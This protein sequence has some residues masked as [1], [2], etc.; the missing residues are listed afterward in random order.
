MVSSCYRVWC[1]VNCNVLISVTLLS[2]SSELLWMLFCC[3]HFFVVADQC[4]H[5]RGRRRR[6]G[7]AQ[8]RSWASWVKSAPADQQE[9]GRRISAQ[10]VRSYVPLTARRT[11]AS[12]A[13]QTDRPNTLCFYSGFWKLVW[14]GFRSFWVVFFFTVFMYFY[15]FPLVF[16]VFPFGFFLYI[17]LLFFCFYSFC[18]YM[19][20]FSNAPWTFFLHMLNKFSKLDEHFSYFIDIYRKCHEHIFKTHEHF[21]EWYETIFKSYANIFFTYETKTMPMST[22]EVYRSRGYAATPT[23]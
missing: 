10:L 22:K 5:G 3:F 7:L 19:W 1:D 15:W 6:N 21:Y 14:T 13:P 2:N 18:K 16:F 4:R 23:S 11:L 8:M 17:F 20:Y 12:A 9:H